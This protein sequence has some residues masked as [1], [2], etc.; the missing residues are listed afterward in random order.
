MQKNSVAMENLMLKST[1]IWNWTHA[2]TQT[3]ILVKVT[4]RSVVGIL[5]IGEDILKPQNLASAAVKFPGFTVVSR[6]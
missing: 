5:R 3:E 2:L 6:N 4:P 1:H